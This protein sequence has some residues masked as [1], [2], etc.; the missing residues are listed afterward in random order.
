MSILKFFDKHRQG[1]RELVLDVE[2]TGL[3]VSE[4]HRIVEVAIVEL[5][6][7][8]PTGRELHVYI[9]PDRHIPDEVVKIH[10]IDDARVANEPKF[11]GLARALRDFIGDDQVIITCRTTNDYTLDIAMMNME[12][13]K[14]GVKTVPETQWTN[15]RRW[16]EQMFGDKAATLDK[17][18][19]KYGVSRKE[20]DDNGHGALLDARLLAAIY[21][22]LKKDW[23]KHKAAAPAAGA[24]QKP[25]DNSPKA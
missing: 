10:G 9:N 14:A 25:K 17:V 11:A 2:S 13:Q 5:I 4:G 23:E 24:P 22:V 20:R 7:K 21:P 6:N 18:L 19:D 15:V 8:K 16:S 1:E 3:F 12:F